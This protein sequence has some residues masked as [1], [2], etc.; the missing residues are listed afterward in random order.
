MAVANFR[1]GMQSNKAINTINQIPIFGTANKYQPTV[2]VKNRDWFNANEISGDALDPMNVNPNNLGGLR[3]VMPCKG[4]A[5]V[6]MMPVGGGV[7]VLRREAESSQSGMYVVPIPGMRHQEKGLMEQ[8]IYSQRNPLMPIASNFN[9]G[10]NS[11]L[12]QPA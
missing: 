1:N 11:R 7:N 10:L 2:V 8:D 6:G 5:S 12:G 9:D 4:I 3:G